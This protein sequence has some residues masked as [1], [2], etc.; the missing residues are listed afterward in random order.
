[1][2]IIKSLLE[3]ESA[4]QDNQKISSVISE[5]TQIQESSE[6]LPED[7]VYTAESVPV[8]GMTQKG[9]KMYVIECDN[10]FKLMESQKQDEVASLLGIKSVLATD[11]PEVKFDDMA[12]LVKDENIEQIQE[13]CKSDKTKEGARIESIAK[14]TNT[15]KNIMAEGVHLLVDR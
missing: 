2:S 7:I 5:L 4:V 14:Y 1:M 10:L 8:F 3:S 15:L 12:V 13:L 6:I 11:D 9:K